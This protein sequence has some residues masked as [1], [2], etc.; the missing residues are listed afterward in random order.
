MTDAFKMRSRGALLDGDRYLV[1]LGIVLLGYAVLGRGFA[2]VGLPPL[3]VGEIALLSGAFVFVRSGALLA[4]LASLPSI[5]L[6]ALIFWVLARTIPFVG[7]Y[8]FDALRD[9]TVVTYGGFALIVIGLLLE[10]ARRIDAV[11]R[12]YNVLLASIPAIFV[13]FCLTQYWIEHV[14][15]LF[16]PVAIVE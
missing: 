7:E 16:G 9:S 13:G 2:Y 12:Y 1:F 4:S 15:M 10:D 8:G 3:F 14:P 6:V 5:L 11:L